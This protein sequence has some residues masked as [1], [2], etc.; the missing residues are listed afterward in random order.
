MHVGFKYIR[1]LGISHLFQ[2]LQEYLGIAG[3]QENAA[4]SRD[5]SRDGV[6]Q[7]DRC[8]PALVSAAAC[9]PN[10]YAALD[11]QNGSARIRTGEPLPQGDGGLMIDDADVRFRGRLIRTEHE[12]G[13]VE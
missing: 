1:G 10:G 3:A 8:I 6:Q 5:T 9:P 12:V 4:P 2:K 13:L 11:G 7:W